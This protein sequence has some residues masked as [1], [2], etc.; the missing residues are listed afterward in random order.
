MLFELHTD[1]YN[2]SVPLHT[3]LEDLMTYL[4]MSFLS[5]IVPHRCQV[6]TNEIRTKA[7]QAL[8]DSHSEPLELRVL[9]GLSDMPTAQHPITAK[10]ATQ[11][12]CGLSVPMP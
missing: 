11:K 1:N 10:K 9:S 5:A 4:E 8:L 2:Y 7:L 3:N 6:K 12:S